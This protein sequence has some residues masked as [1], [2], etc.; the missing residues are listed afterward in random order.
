M[1]HVL[2][3]FFLILI[4]LKSFSQDYSKPILKSVIFQYF[5][6]V[7]SLK[8]ENNTYKHFYLKENNKDKKSKPKWYIRLGRSCL[9]GYAG[10]Y[11]GWKL[12][13][14][15]NIAEGYDEV[16]YGLIFV[17]GGATIGIVVGWIM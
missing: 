16:G 13:E 1:K 11:L 8:S 2:F 10:P 3:V 4:P 12:S 9:L 5:S 14:K 6:S 17:V 15:L 7:D